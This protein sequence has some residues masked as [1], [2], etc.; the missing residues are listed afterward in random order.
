MRGHREHVA[1]RQR[2]QSAA[3]GSGAH[4]DRATR[5]CAVVPEEEPESAVCTAVA[6]LYWDRDDQWVRLA[7]DQHGS[8]IARMADL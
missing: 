2:I 4:E 1:D 6:M 8:D 7:D 5:S 3:G